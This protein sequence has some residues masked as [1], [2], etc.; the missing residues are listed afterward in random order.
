MICNNNELVKKIKTIVISV[1]CLIVSAFIGGFWGFNE[2]K[3]EAE[4]SGYNEDSITGNICGGL[5]GLVGGAGGWALGVTLA[6]ETLGFSLLTPSV[7]S[8]S[9]AYYV[10]KL[11]K[12]EGESIGARAT[13]FD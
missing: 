5:G 1:Y 2:G 8:G 10:S 11:G 3:L 13:C 4:R 6:P 9:G 12:Y 7:L